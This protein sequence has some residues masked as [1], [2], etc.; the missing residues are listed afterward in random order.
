MS[1]YYIVVKMSEQ[2]IEEMRIKVEK[3]EARIAEIITEQD[4]LDR[5]M[6]ALAPGRDE[7]FTQMMNARKAL[8]KKIVPLQDALIDLLPWHEVIDTRADE[9]I[10]RDMTNN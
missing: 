1:I 8:T 9:E 5:E 3:I 6:A 10:F 2:I 7:E 4:E